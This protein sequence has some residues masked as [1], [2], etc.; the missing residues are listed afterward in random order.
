MKNASKTKI[1]TSRKNLL[2]P[3]TGPRSAGWETL[4]Y[5]QYVKLLAFP[6]QQL[7]HKSS[8]ML[9]FTYIVCLV[10]TVPQTC[11]SNMCIYDYMFFILLFNFINYVFLMLYLCTI[12]K[13]KGKAIPLQV[14]TGTENF[15]RHMKLVRLSVL[16]TGRLYPPTKYLW[17]SFLLQSESTP[18]PLCGRK[19]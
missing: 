19:D 9:L 4:L 7:L 11:P 10:N 16:L 15:R 8:S 14:W 18:G 5:S 12:G 13:G 2:R 3:S 17:Y 1:T 6:I